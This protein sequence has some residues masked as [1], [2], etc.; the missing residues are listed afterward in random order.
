MNY[1]EFSM[2]QSDAL[3]SVVRMSME[4]ELG[5][6]CVMGAIYAARDFLDSGRLAASNILAEHVE[7][8]GEPRAVNVDEEV[9][10]GNDMDQQYLD[11]QV[12]GVKQNAMSKD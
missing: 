10:N 7:N 2:Q 3:I 8:L 1:L 12:P 9:V 11:L 4:E 6:P 5:M